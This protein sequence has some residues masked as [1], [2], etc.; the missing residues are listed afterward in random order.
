[1]SNSILNEIMAVTNDGTTEDGNS[2]KAQLPAYPG[3]KPTKS[4]MLEWRD[5]WTDN[6]KSNGFSAQLRG[7]EPFE[8][9]KLAERPRVKIPRDAEPAR[10]AT[11]ESKNSD[12]DHTNFINMAEKD[13][14][15]LEI[16]SRMV[17][18]LSKAMRTTAPLKLATLYEKHKYVD[19]SG[20][21]VPGAYHGVNMF[22]E[23][24]KE[25]DEGCVSEYSGQEY[26]DAY[27]HIKKRPL[28]DNASP[29]QYSR[30]INQFTV[31]VNPFMN[32]PL[33]GEEL[34]RFIVGQLPPN[35]ESDA[36]TLM[37][38]LKNKQLLG[39]PGNTC[40]EGLKLIE[41]AYKPN[42]KVA[43][44]A[45]VVSDVDQAAATGD[46]L[47]ESKVQKLINSA[48]K[49]AVNAAT[50]P[51]T[52]DTRQRFGRRAGGQAAGG[53]TSGRNGKAGRFQIPDGK[54][55]SEGW[56]TFNHDEIKPGEPCYRSPGFTGPVPIKTWESLPQ[57]ERINEA[58]KANA[59]KSGQTYKPLVAPSGT[60]VKMVAA[61]DME[62]GLLDLFDMGAQINMV[63]AMLGDQCLSATDEDDSGGY[64]FY[65]A[66]ALDGADALSPGPMDALT[67]GCE[68]E[69]VSDFGGYEDSEPTPPPAE[70]SP[71]Y[72]T[73]I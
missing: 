72:A 31:K 50:G 43:L 39:D 25:A 35:L 21:Q 29:D 60:N 51:V 33:K 53:D 1:M 48:V 2:V 10:V 34:S 5:A 67:S 4:Q 22:L 19:L 56:C 55:C 20:N 62:G 32:R 41:S 44:P 37:R 64:D 54:T 24:S 23:L 12:I 70:P 14:R 47:S 49:T 28:P 73:P 36:R 45:N 7:Q 13:A 46:G 71:T 40:A 69:E 38:E 17:G 15:L 18:K 66:D 8:I 59:V 57:R 6:L 26:E 65:T 11:L 63:D 3:E 9:M 16:Q 30:R 27:D 42:R 58:K 52:G 61:P 68:V